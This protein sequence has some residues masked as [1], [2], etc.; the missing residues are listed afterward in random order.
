MNDRISAVNSA[1]GTASHAPVTPNRAGS[2]SMAI[3]I[4]TKD[5]EKARTAEINPLD[6]AVN[7]PL[8]N[9]LKPIKISATEQIRFP[10]TAKS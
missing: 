2:I 5:L 4:K 1:A 10:V 9:T 3:T 6:S 8:M 7:I